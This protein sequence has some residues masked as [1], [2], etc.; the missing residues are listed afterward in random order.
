L[1]NFT[2]SVGEDVLAVGLTW[3]ATRHP[4]LAGT[5]A[6]ALILAVLFAVRLVIRA[7]RALF[8]GARHEFAA[9]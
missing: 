7:M 4:Y 1:S 9:D 5:V 2:L 6:A 8:R 3:L